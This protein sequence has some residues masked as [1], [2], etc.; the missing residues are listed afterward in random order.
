MV[1]A[2]HTRQATRAEGGYRAVAALCGGMRGLSTGGYRRGGTISGAWRKV[3]R[4]G[5]YGVARVRERAIELEQ[6][7]DEVD[8]WLNWL[9]RRFDRQ[10]VHDRLQQLQA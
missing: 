2:R 7:R 6:L 4:M 9:D 5:V 10:M 8:K 3:E 1:A